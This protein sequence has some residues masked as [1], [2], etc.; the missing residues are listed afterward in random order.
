MTA[1]VLI[2]YFNQ[3]FFSREG[4][5]RLDDLQD[6]NARAGRKSPARNAAFW[7]LLKHAG[8]ALGSMVILDII[9]F[10]GF[11]RPKSARPCNYK[12]HCPRFL[13]CAKREFPP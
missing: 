10:F 11:V 2:V 7:P 9:A 6:Q 1:G 12:T 5:P 8:G 3:A 13:E 4:F